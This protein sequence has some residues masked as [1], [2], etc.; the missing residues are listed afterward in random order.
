MSDLVESVVRQYFLAFERS[1]VDELV[2]LFRED[3]VYTDGP[4]GTY[5]GVDE[6][7]GELQS[8]A[9]AVSS[10]SVEIKA[11]V[12]NG[13]TVM[14]ERVDR[15]ETR[16]KSFQLDVVGVFEVDKDGRIRRF[17]DYFDLKSLTDRIA[18][19]FASDKK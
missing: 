7:S 2:K 13:D 5:R 1:D 9:K 8:Q 15:F 19:E 10:I 4:R 11:L 6:I 16:G 3:A 18:A 17:R 12:S 14:V